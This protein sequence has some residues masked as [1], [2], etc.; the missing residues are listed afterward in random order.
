MTVAKNENAL[1]HGMPDWPINAKIPGVVLSSTQ[2]VYSPD[3]GVKCSSRE[4]AKRS[5]T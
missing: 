4:G 1:Y 3:T 2:P 5:K